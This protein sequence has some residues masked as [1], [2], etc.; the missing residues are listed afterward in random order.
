ML[1]SGFNPVIELLVI[2]LRVWLYPH[3]VWVPKRVT[4]AI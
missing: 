2:L 1:N 4:R 3:S